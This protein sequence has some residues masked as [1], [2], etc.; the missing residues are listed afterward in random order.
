MQKHCESDQANSVANSF[1]FLLT[2]PAVAQSRGLQ[3]LSF[4]SRRGILEP[5][6]E[7]NK[8]KNLKKKEKEK[9]RKTTSQNEYMYT[10]IYIH[11]HTKEKRQLEPIQ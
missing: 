3:F 1:L 7:T 11:I 2:L 4:G 5:N 10:Y 9:K 6:D 8:E